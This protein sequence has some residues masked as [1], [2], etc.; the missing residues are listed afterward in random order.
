MDRPNLINSQTNIFQVSENNL[1]QFPFA[2]LNKMRKSS[3][4]NLDFK[5]FKKRVALLLKER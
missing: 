4:P 2:P 3:L 1:Q 5:G